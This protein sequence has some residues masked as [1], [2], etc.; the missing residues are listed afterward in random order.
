MRF[1]NKSMGIYKTKVS[2][3]IAVYNGEKTLPL[4]L[5][6]LMN[7]DYPKEDLEII[8]VDNASTDNTKE[9]VAKYPVNYV[10]E[11]EAKQYSAALNR[12]I[13][14]SQGEF[15]AFTHADCVIDRY[16]VSNLLSGFTDEQIAGCGGKVLPYGL[17]TLAQRYIA[18]KTLNSQWRNICSKQKILPHILNANAMY[19]RSVIEQIGFF[20]E[21][22][23]EDMEIDLCWR[24]FLTG[25]RFNYTKDAIVYHKYKESISSLW[26]QQFNMAVNA[27]R[28]IKKYGGIIS[29]IF[30]IFH[31]EPIRFLSELII[32]VR[33]FF[34]SLIKFRSN[35][36]FIPLYYLLD[37]T[38]TFAHL[39]GGFW[40]VY[41]E[42]KLRKNSL[43]LRKVK[44]IVYRDFGDEIIVLNTIT[45]SY[46][47]LKDISAK[48][49]RKLNS[50]NRPDEVMNYLVKEYGISKEQARQD[51]DEYLN[52]LVQAGLLIKDGSLMENKSNRKAII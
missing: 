46:F 49:W 26:R 31:R 16:W 51:V 24:I 42:R 14:N 29:P 10:Y 5:D 28:F 38:S 20:D 6:S 45:K 30:L 35:S 44:K 32:S 37:M 48:I 1:S 50:E 39:A 40:G 33:R 17:D 4:C 22:F 27:P 41:I 21:Y 47:S 3:V 9:L 23:S 11:P 15:I 7:L 43:P 25:Y 18:S 36:D 12:G 8:V 34:N 19:R 52:E 13:Q 2:I